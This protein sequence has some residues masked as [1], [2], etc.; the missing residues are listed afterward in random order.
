[1]KKLLLFLILIVATFAA[2]AANVRGVVTCEGKGV[3][4]VVV[5]D[6]ISATSTNKNGAYRLK[7]DNKRS[8]FVYISVPSGYEVPSM[9]GFMPDFYRSLSNRQKVY[10]FSLKAVDQSKYHLIVS[11][12]IHVRNRCMTKSEPLRQTPLSNPVGELDSATFARTYMTTL[13]NY[14]AKLPSDTK[15]YGLNLGDVSNESHWRGRYGG[16]L[17]N[18]VEVCRRSGM[19]IQTFTAIGNHEHDMKARDIFDDDDTA[20]ELEYM[21]VFGPTYYSLNIGGVHYVVLDNVKYC[22]HKSEGKDRNYEVRFTQ[23]QID[24]VKKDAALMPKDTKHVVFAWHCPSYRRYLGGKAKHNAD[25]I[26][27]NYAPYN[28]PMTILTGHN[29]QSEVVKV[30]NYPNTTEY[31]HPSVSGS[32]WYYPLCNDGSPATFTRYDFVDGALTARESVNFTDH[33]EQKYRIYN[34]GV[35]NKSGERVIRLNIWDWHP[36][37][38]FD[39]YENG[40]KVAEP[41]FGNIRAKDRLYD[42]MREATGNGIKKFRFLNTARTYHIFEYKPQD[43]AADIRIVATDEFG[44]VYFDVTTHME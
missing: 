33:A 6:G 19:P 1:M 43:V 41:H 24:W 16:D 21:K 5:T 44:S 42:E 34:K 11:A 38:R 8:H 32:W 9:R 18:F 13:R 39:I 20:A 29:H 2:E 4:G 27:S 28:L 3:A 12:D 14:V 35:V 25:E 7:T 15:V 31:I 10:N 26:V 30:A 40:K 37:W 22:N 36:D 23:D 17:E